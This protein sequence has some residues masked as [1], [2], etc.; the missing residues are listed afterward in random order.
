MISTP[1]TDLKTSGSLMSPLERGWARALVRVVPSG[2]RGYHLTLASI[3]WCGC[4]AAACLLAPGDHRWLHLLSGVIVAQ[5]V[6]DAVDGKI[7]KLR[8]DG[9]VRWGYYMDHMLDYAFLAVILCGYG[10]LLPP[11]W[12]GVAGP[13]VA[14]G[15]GFMASAFLAR[16][17]T[18]VLPIA[19]AGV[20]PVEMRAVFVAINTVIASV[21]TASWIQAVPAALACAALVLCAWICR[22]QS[23]LWALD[24]ESRT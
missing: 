6:T 8:G 13:M 23:R 10:A 22:T 12:R 18:G 1:M 11:D 14:V 2:V 20:G 24:R 15:G 3:L 9:L 17:A 16:G 7:G 4:A 21:G 5:Y 19:F